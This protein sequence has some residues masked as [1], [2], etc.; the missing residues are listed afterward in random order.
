[1]STTYP[2]A[3]AVLRARAEA[4]VTLPM[5]WQFETNEISD[6]AEAFVYFEMVGQPAGF[7]EVG[8]GRG[9]NRYRHN[10]EF[11]A[12]VFVPIGWGMQDALNRAEAVATLFRSFHESGVS[13]EGAEIHPVGEGAQLVPPGLQSAAGNYACAVVRVP[14]HFDQIA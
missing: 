14:L 5:F 8:G 12:F 4:N 7:I 6:T 2:A 1:M 13:C 9:A 11:N 3:W 10:A